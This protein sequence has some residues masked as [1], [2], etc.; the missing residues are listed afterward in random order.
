M[1]EVYPEISE[2]D[3]EEESSQELTSEVV[4]SEEDFGATL[5]DPGK[6]TTAYYIRKAESALDALKNIVK[7][8]GWKKVLTHNKSGVVVYSKQGESKESKIPVFMGQQDIEGF[9]PQS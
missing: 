1:N 9:P 8:N 3:Y 6:F 5:V 4:D 2:E 7:E